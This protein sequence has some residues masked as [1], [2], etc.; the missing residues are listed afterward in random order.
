MPLKYATIFLLHQCYHGVTVK[1]R[2]TG[3]IGCGEMVLFNDVSDVCI[4]SILRVANSAALHVKCILKNR[5]QGYG[6]DSSGWE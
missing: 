3:T 2:P 6:M 5:L 4:D 1:I